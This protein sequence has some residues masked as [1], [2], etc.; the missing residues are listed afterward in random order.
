MRAWF[1]IWA[2]VFSATWSKWWLLSREHLPTRHPVLVLAA[3]L[4]KTM[5]QASSACCSPVSL[6]PTDQAVK[7][8]KSHWVGDK[9]QRIC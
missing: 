3:N 9:S 2:S 1:L 5:V 4:R 8:G 6:V 7:T